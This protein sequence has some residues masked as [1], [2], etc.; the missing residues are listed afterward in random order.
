MRGGKPQ[1][2]ASKPDHLGALGG[3]RTGIWRKACKVS[4]NVTPQM[5]PSQVQTAIR[6]HRV[7]DSFPDVSKS[8][9]D[10]AQQSDHGS[11]TAR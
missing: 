4:R 11:G 6:G 2:S 3:V 10:K 1:V 8:G 5:W 7:R 9:P